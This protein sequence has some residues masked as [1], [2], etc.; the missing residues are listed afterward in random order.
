MN[1]QDNWDAALLYCNQLANGRY[2]FA[3][4]VLND[5]EGDNIYKSLEWEGYL[6]RRIIT[7]PQ[8]N[9]NYRRVE[10]EI[11]RMGFERIEKLTRY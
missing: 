11:T 8:A 4:A 10:Y 2:W 5:G 6:K 9:P 3:L 7:T 1:S